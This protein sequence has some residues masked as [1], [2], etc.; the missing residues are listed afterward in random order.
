MRR[1]AWMSV[2]AALLI[3]G[4]SGASS[5]PTASTEPT[6]AATSPA[7]ASVR[8]SADATSSVVPTSSPR[9][10]SRPSPVAPIGAKPDI[11][12]GDLA[13]TVGDNLRLRAKPEVS[14]ASTTYTMLRWGTRLAILVAPVAGSGYWWC[15]VRVIGQ[16]LE[17][18][19]AVAARDGTRW[20]VNGE[21]AILIALQGRI[22]GSWTGTVATPWV[23]SYRVSIAFRNGTYSARALSGSN[24]ALYWGSDTD[25]PLKTYAIR[26]VAADG[27]A[28]GDIV[29]Y[30]DAGKSTLVHQL[31]DIAFQGDRLLFRIW[32]PGASGPISFDLT[33]TR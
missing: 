33:R 1:V 5:S 4:C 10:S 13:L 23:G 12:A 24:P 29:L 19:A 28:S 6:G 26:D 3:T 14:T 9:P 17:G 27:M 15:R 8:P 11:R 25:S 32:H 20:I 18:W 31:T 16:Q 7:A 30:W 2:V 22:V 21:A